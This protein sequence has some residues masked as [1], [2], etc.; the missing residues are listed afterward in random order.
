LATAIAEAILAPATPRT[1]SIQQVQVRLTKPAAPI[2]DF[3]GAIVIE[4]LRS[5]S[6]HIE[7]P[8]G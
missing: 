8:P 7:A 3:G 6:S 4:I 5:V 2:P 1:I